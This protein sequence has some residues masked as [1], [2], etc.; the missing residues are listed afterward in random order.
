MPGFGL[1]NLVHLYLYAAVVLSWELAV[2]DLRL[3]ELQV[4]LYLN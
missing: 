2:A 3:P 4:L 1:G